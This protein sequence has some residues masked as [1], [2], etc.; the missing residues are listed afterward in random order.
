MKQSRSTPFRLAVVLIAVFAVFLSAG[1]GT[2]YVL[3]H[4]ALSSDIEDRGMQVVEEL[5]KIDDPEELLERAQE[6]AGAAE[7]D[8]LLL[9]VG[10]GATRAGN[11]PPSGALQGII[12]GDSLPLEDTADSYLAMTA[13]Q[14]AGEVTVLVGREAVSELNETFVAILGY[15]FLPALFITWA[16]AIVA[17]RRTGRRVEGIRNTL[18]AISEGDLR[19]RVGGP[20]PDTDLGDIE[21]DLDRM[22]TAQEAATEAL[23]QIGSDIAHDLKTPIQRVAVH[24]ERLEDADLSDAAADAL[25][26]ARSETRGIIGTFQSLLQIAQ[27]EGGQGRDTFGP[28]HLETLVRDMVEIYGPAVE[29]AGGTLGFELRQPQPVTGDRHLLSR[30]VANLIENALRHAPGTEI[31]IEIDAG[32]LRVTDGGPGIPLEQ[33]ENVL[34]RLVRLEASR[35]TPGSGLGLALVKAIADQHGA[36]LTLGDAPAGG[37]SVTVTFP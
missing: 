3:M 31:L 27:L 18:H 5:R 34:R 20:Y 26:A 29:E 12:P 36:T 8:R 37:L 23:R 21:R 19:A 22:A 7:P 24:L 11:L 2:A 35:S 16:I 13:R 4:R 14:P 9:A 25:E 32:T 15:S 6:I 1:L 17:V 33:R 30:L 10:I 28:V